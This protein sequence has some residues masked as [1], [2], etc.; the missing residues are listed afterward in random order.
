MEILGSSSDHLILDSNHHLKI[1]SEVKFNL[2]YGGLLSAMTSPF[3]KK[4][5][6]GC[7]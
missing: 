6:V 7:S 1:G 3:V 2:D 4:Q 5:F